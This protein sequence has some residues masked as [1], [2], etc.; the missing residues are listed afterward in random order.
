LQGIKQAGATIKHVA[1]NNSGISIVNPPKTKKLAYPICTFTY[2]IVPMT[3]AHAA[4]LKRFITWALTKGQADGPQLLFSPLPK[5]VQRA[6][7]RTIALVH[8]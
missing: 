4:D 8:S 2:V 1:Q 5:A 3:T 7:L 6:S